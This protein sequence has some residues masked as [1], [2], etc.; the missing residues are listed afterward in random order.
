MKIQ[1]PFYTQISTAFGTI[2]IVW[3][4][5]TGPSRV[6]RICLNPD[7]QPVA[8]VIRRIYPD[9]QPLSSPEIDRFASHIQRFLEGEAVVFNLDM[10]AMETCKPFQRR[11]LLADY[12]IPRGHVNTYGNIAR[13]IGV[14]GGSR[15]TGQA[16]AQNPFPLVIPCH[17]VVRADGGI[18]GY[19]GGA[20]MKRALLTME[21]VAFTGRGTVAL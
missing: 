17:R 3:R 4:R 19:R 9:A 11:V 7:R 12:E 2:G 8:D 15:A 14:T 10:V 20:D 21:G 6:W 18:G 1:P 13:R 5:T 16:L